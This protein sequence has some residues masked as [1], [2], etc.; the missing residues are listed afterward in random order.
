M[1]FHLARGVEAT[2]R[3]GQGCQV[4]IVINHSE[5]ARS[6][7]LPTAMRDL[8]EDHA[9]ARKHLAL[10]AYGVAVLSRADLRAQRGEAVSMRM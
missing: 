1:G 7:D 4:W 10:P 2:L 5:Q 3:L 9:P 6:L 8:L